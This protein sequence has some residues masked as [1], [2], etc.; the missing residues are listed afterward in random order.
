MNKLTSEKCREFIAIFKS[1]EKEGHLALTSEYHLQAYEKA[2]PILEQQEQ[3]QEVCVRE[4]LAALSAHIDSIGGY[5]FE[6]LEAYRREEFGQQGRGGCKWHYDEADCFWSSECG[7]DW[8]FIDGGPEENRV[9]F[10]QGCGQPVVL[11]QQ[12]RGCQKCGGTGMA[13]SGGIQ[14][15]GEQILIECDCKFEQ[16]ERS[17]GGWIDWGGG[18][19]P[20][21]PGDRVDLKLRGGVITKDYPAECAQWSHHKY[22]NSSDIIAYRIIPERAT[23]Q[24]GDAS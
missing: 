13:D 7:E 11:E 22:N 20:V 16:Q 9:K 12:E 3:K 10:C 5:N 14:P 6:A 17:E 24:N 19:R 8:Q 4:G 1:L 21:N 18:E 23:N 2:L 15:W